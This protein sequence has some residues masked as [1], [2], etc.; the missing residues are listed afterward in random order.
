M[1]TAKEQ[2]L[3]EKIEKA[4]KDLE[5]LQKKRKLELGDLAYQYQLNQFDNSILAQ[6]F[7]KLSKE[8]HHGN[9]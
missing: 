5:V 6:A 7:E 1:N 9:Q 4:K 2:K 8:L 3:L